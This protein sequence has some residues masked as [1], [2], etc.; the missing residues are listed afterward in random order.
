MSFEC[1]IGID[2]AKAKL[3]VA[4][5]ASSKVH[6]VTNDPQGHRE[7]IQ[8]LP[9]PGQCLIVLEAT[10]VYERAIVLALVDAKHIVSVV[11]PRQIRDYARA[12]GKLAK[13]DQIDA[14]VIADYGE[15]VRPRAL[16]KT[17][18][19]QAEMNALVARRRQLIQSRTSEKNR[20]LQADSK[21]IR[22]SVQRIL[23]SLNK[24][25]RRIEI[26]IQSLVKSDDDWRQKLEL[27]K[28]APGV[29]DVTSATLIAELPELG[30]L[31]RKQITALVGVA[32]LNRDSGN[33]RGQRTIF[34]GRASVRAALYMATLTAKKHNP[35]IAHF[36]TRLLNAGKSP[37]VVLVACMRKLLTIL[38]VMIRNNSPW[39][40]TKTA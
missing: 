23:D 24:E 11:N 35:V 14:R 13:T 6:Q 31:N 12:V 7:L 15:K 19:K 10:G 36:A 4:F 40:N 25:I 29:G 22:K 38:N 28:S 30:K 20:Q 34:G 3:D 2:V 16:D 26:E 17:T 18:E 37:K 21:I 33:K 1:F 9:K 27:L 32:P 8:L 39:Q 5:N